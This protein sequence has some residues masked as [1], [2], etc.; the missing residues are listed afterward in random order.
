MPRKPILA[1]AAGGTAAAIAAIVITASTVGLTPSTSGGSRDTAEAPAFA[2]G[3]AAQSVV[4]ASESDGRA[5][6]AVRLTDERLS[7]GEHEDDDDD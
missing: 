2:P 6:N 5:G 7:T 4:T 3:V 1:Y